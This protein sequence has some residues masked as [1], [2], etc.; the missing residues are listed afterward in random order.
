M[1]SSP[2]PL[3]FLGAGWFSSVMGLCGLALAWHRAVPLMGEMADAASLVLGG[4][5]ALW[6]VILLALYLLRRSRHAQAATEDFRHPVRHP[7]VAALPI[8]IVL[9]AAVGVNLFGPNPWFSALW[10]TGAAWQFAVTLWLLSRWFNGNKD[11]GL[12]WAGVTPVL[13]LPVVGNVLV[14]L[15]GVPLGF[16]A[17]SLAQFGIGLFFWPMVLLLLFARIAV[18]GMWPERLMASTFITVAP[19]AVVGMVLLQWGAPTP[20]AWMA[21][22]VALFFLAWSAQVF[23]RVLAQPF[24]L[25]FWALSFP[26]A[27]FC[28]L[29]LRLGQGAAPWFGALGMV[30]LALST[31][32]AAALVLATY[33][34]WRAGTLLVPEQIALTEAKP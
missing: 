18:Q 34:G 19:P 33:K 7:F 30:L 8:S 32:V 2:T 13:F 26:L 29:T 22:G 17:W 31:L 16:E 4:L 5:A 15:A 24:S 14:P 11:G 6:F 10:I 27:A 21:W 20:L 28:A 9:L 3:K 1:T 23:K 12:V 25:A